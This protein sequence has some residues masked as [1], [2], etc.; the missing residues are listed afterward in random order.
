MSPRVLLSSIIQPFGPRHGDGFFV[1]A[2]SNHQIFWA[3]DAFRIQTT[4]NQWGI[5]FIAAN[6][7]APTTCLHYPSMRQFLREL[8]RGYDYLGIAFVASTRHKMEAMV[9]AARQHAP[10][11]KIVLGGYGT[12]QIQETDAIADHVCRG[13]GVA[14]MRQ[15]LGESSD[16]PLVQPDI[17][18]TQTLFSLPMPNPT[19]FVFAGLGC[20]NGCDFCATSHFFKRKHIPFL[21]S[22][23]SVVQAMVD[24]RRRHQN[25]N[26]FTVIDEDLLLNESRG[27]EFLTAMRSSNLPPLSLSVFSS[28]K[29]LSQ[30]RASELVEMG[31]DVVWVGYEGQRANYGKQ[32]GRSYEELFS[33]LRHHGISVLASAILGLDYQTEEIVKQEFEELLRLEPT[34]T[35]FL[36]YGPNFGTPLH[37]RMLAED[38]LDQVAMSQPNKLDGC[39]LLFRHEHFSTKQIQTLQRKLYHEAFARL[40]PSVFRVVANWLEGYRTLR[41]HP[42]PRV[43]DKARR[44]G[45]DI[46]QALPALAGSRYFA[47]LASQD[48]LSELQQ[49]ITDVIGPMSKKQQLLAHLIPAMFR[50][51]RL[52][53]THGIGMQPTHSRHSHRWPN[54]SFR[55]MQRLLEG[56]LAGPARR[57]ADS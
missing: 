29:A 50:L 18:Q 46:H 5:E 51:T 25:L 26:S 38:R 12:T 3:Q 27:R 35:Q 9:R 6:I 21:K 7:Q 4:N 32:A 40:G 36:I 45:E 53:M 14:F 10:N 48:W 57:A 52:R 15:L 31:I 8:R 39:S 42:Q 24:L 23:D 33:D 2:D 56:P 19:G 41:D 22:G 55:L 13:E 1:T 28:V 49:E 54:K 37:A 16:P 34:L 43:R 11:T 20:P 30:Y 47:P 17:T 44:Y